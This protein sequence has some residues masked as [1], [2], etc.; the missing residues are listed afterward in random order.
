[1]DTVRPQA[2]AKGLALDTEIDAGSEDALI[3]DPTR[4]RQILLNLM[5]NAVKFTERGSVRVSV[6]TMP[7][8]E[9]RTR[10]TITVSDTG[11]GLDDAQQA[12]LFQPFAQADSSTTRRFGGTGLG[13][14]IVRRLAHLMEGDIAVE[15]AAGVGSRFTVTLLL[16]AAPVDSPLK[17]LLNKAAGPARARLAPNGPRVLVVDDHPINREVLVR[18]LALL[19][20]AADDAADAATALEAWSPGRYAAMLADIH[21]PIIDGRE[22][23]RLLRAAEA[24]SGAQPMPIVAVTADAMKGEEER[25]LAAGMDAYLAKPVSVER[26]R[27]TLARWLPLDQAG[28]STGAPAIDRHAL[29]AWLGDEPGAIDGLLAKFRASAIDSENEIV[30][31]A[32]GGDFAAVAAAAHRL[33]GAAQAVGAT[34]VAAAAIALEHAGKAGDHERCRD[35]LGPLASELRR[36]LAEV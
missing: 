32:H 9:G 34:G 23:T 22:L 30:A 8:G 12:R 6:A 18:Q 17:T 35:G 15:S 25:C 21:M 2:A 31:A 36:A 5:G 28:H 26:L 20:I 13:L 29:E 7:L 19:G 1:M 16:Q 24:Q 33:R 14:S 27:M 4:V 11:I 10:V 3:G